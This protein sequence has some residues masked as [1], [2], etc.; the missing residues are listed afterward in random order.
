MLSTICRLNPLQKTNLQLAV[1]WLPFPRVQDNV[2]VQMDISQKAKNW[3]S[4]L[5]RLRPEKEDKMVEWPIVCCKVYFTKRIF[6]EPYM[7]KSKSKKKWL[8]HLFIWVKAIFGDL[9]I[10]LFHA[11]IARAY[12]FCLYFILNLA[13]QESLYQDETLCHIGW[14]NN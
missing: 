10:S 7:N 11:R 14:M 12:F 4:I 6:F 8:R 1:S 2:V 9:K 13:L 3:N 5:G